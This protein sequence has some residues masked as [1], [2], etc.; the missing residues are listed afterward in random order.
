[1]PRRRRLECSASAPAE[2]SLKDDATSAALTM[3]EEEDGVFIA[4]AAV[5]ISNLVKTSFCSQ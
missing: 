5:S 4:I 3:T 2:A 1:M